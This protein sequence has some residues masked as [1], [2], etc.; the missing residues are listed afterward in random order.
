MKHEFTLLTTVLYSLQKLFELH[1]NNAYKTENF[2]R[3]ARV[4]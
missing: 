3:S 2:L 1:S 4:H